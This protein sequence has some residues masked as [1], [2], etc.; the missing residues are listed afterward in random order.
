MNRHNITLNVHWLYV[1]AERL[2]EEIVPSLKFSFQGSGSVI[3]LIVFRI[4]DQCM[5]RNVGPELPVH[6]T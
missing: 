1:C 5:S 6:A 3:G 2:G 4:W